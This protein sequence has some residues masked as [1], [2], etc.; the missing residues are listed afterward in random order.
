MNMLF[1]LREQGTDVLEL[2]IFESIGEGGFFFSAL[3]AEQVR[4]KLNSRPDAKT[5]RV[6]INSRGGE[7]FEGLA[8]YEELRSHPARV[9]V[10]I[11]ALAASI[12]S[13]I[14]MAGD[15][16]AIAPAGFLMMHGVLGGA[17]GDADFLEDIADMMRKAQA[18]IAG[19]YAKRSKQPVAK[20]EEWLSRETYMTAEEAL[21][22][23]LV[24]RIDDKITTPRAQAKAFAMLNSAKLEGAP[25][26]LLEAIRVSSEPTPSPPPSPTPSHEPIPVPAQP[27][28]TTATNPAEP[29][30]KLPMSEDPKTTNP[31]SAI[32]A[33]LGLIA[34]AS[35]TDILA[36]LGRLRD[37][38]VQ[39]SAI[40]EVTD[41]A[42][43]VGA[44]RG[45]KAKADTA[46]AAQA[47]L[48]Q[49]KAE[50]DRQT[51]DSLIAKG[52]ADRK[53][54]PAEAKFEQEKF[55][56][57]LAENRGA[58]AVAAL[59][60]YLAVAPRKFAEPKTQ[61]STTSAG[62]GG[63]MTWNGKAYAELAPMEKHR[64]KAD[65]PEL[66]AQMRAEHARQVA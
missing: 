61:P 65:D 48:A 53:L 56:S 66:Y 47:E 24:D 28:A 45:T 50:R 46:D 35:E 41:S 13:A 6:T 54:T 25:D 43:L 19:V 37:L 11:Q 55:D 51:F 21:A 62:G 42:Q 4:R 8:I 33:S 59:Q 7:V 1:N 17:R 63:A 44:I 52:Q 16:I 18:V 14:A 60:G 5:I 23:G 27:V 10:K 34:G 49:V 40:L 20:V 29:E 30:R 39:A 15:D 36:R 2:D 22:N 64:L 38:E 32:V 3:S 9:E 57:A 31:Y 26:A 58:Q 12:A